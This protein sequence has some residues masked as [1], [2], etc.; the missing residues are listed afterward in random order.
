[1]GEWDGRRFDQIKKQSP[2][3]FEKRGKDIYTYKVPGGESF[4]DVSCRAVPYFEHCINTLKKNILIVTHAGVIR[5]ILCHLLKMEP[6]DL[7]QIKIAYG[8][9]FVVQPDLFST[10]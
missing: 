4:H 6:T 9:L 5:V 3:E 2:E 10:L 7:F 8:Q 1:M